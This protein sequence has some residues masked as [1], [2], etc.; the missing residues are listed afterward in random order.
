MLEMIKTLLR[1]V[2]M[3]SPRRYLFTYIYLF[4]DGSPGHGFGNIE[5]ESKNR[6]KSVEEIGR[7]VEKA[8]KAKDDE[9]SLVGKLTI[10]NVLPFPI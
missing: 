10:T 4:R 2:G 6:F 9:N 7:A 8:L 1:I 3:L 5:I